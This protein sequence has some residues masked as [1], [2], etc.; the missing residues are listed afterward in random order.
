M[1]NF[2]ALIVDDEEELA[3]TLVE[4]LGY[5]GIKAQYAING[6]LALEVL[7]DSS[8]DVI[9]VDL[10]LPGIS[11][12][13]LLGIINKAYPDIPVLMITGHG[14]GEGSGFEKMTGAFE[15]LPKPIDIS[16]LINKMKKAIDAYASR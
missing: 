8:F 2:C 16:E 7:K 9:V 11:G 13:E 3:S 4:R 5:R 10:K 1:D 12:E 14:C 15:F 6:D